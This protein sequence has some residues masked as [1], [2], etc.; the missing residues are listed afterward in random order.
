MGSGSKLSL[1]VIEAAEEVVKRTKKAEELRKAMAVVLS[2]KLRISLPR[3]GELIGRS[4]ATVAR[5]HGEFKAWISDR[6]V[7]AK[8][9]GG[10]RRAYLT[11]EGERKFLGGFFESAAR[12][13]ILIVGDIQEAL[14]E[15]L[16]HKVAQTTVYRMLARYGW[17]KIVPRPRHPKSNELA[18]GE[19]KKNWKR[20]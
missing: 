15:K 6:E 19:F 20:K 11:V 2:G 5:F 4:R 3:V 7:T 1:E 13:G 12:G 8:S 17:R 18:K 16:G 10:R 14:E 9:W